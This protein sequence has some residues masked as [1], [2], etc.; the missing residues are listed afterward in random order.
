MYVSFIISPIFFQFPIEAVAPNFF[1]NYLDAGI[2]VF[3]KKGSAI[4][5][6]NAFTSDI[7]DMFTRRK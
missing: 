6:H 5:W 3:G 7:N 2:S 1:P 4:F